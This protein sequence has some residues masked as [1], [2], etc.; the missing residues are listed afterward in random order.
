MHVCNLYLIL[1]IGLYYIQCMHY[2]ECLFFNFVFFF[3][4]IMGL[5]ALN[6]GK[7]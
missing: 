3:A 1:A 5:N 6:F 7:I 2:T 4:R